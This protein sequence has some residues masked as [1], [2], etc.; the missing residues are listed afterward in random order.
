MKVVLG[1]GMRRAV[2]ATAAASTISA[3]VGAGRPLSP[4]QVVAVVHKNPAVRIVCYRANRPLTSGSG[5]IIEAHNYVVTNHHVVTHEYGPL[6]FPAERICKDL[7]VVIDEGTP[8]E[9]TYPARVVGANA[10]EDLAVVEIPPP[11]GQLPVLALGTRDDIRTG[12][13]VHVPSYPEAGPFRDPTGKIVGTMPVPPG[14]DIVWIVMDVADSVREGSSGGSVLSSDGKVLG[15]AFMGAR[16]RRDCPP[17]P[18]GPS[19]RPRP[20]VRSWPDAQTANPRARRTA[21]GQT[22]RRCQ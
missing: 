17:P 15:V 4:N 8:T 13:P 2:L 3:C 11:H 5:F 14:C 7:R 1:G 6:S 21:R 22:S 12:S 20:P 9:Y 18:P 10:G 19:V 16:T